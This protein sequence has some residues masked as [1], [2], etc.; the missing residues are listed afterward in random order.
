[1]DIPV[2]YK[3]VPTGICEQDPTVKSYTGNVD[4][5]KGQQTFFWFFEAI[6]MDPENAPLTVWINVQWKHYSKRM[7]LVG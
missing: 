3:E 7:D 1:V 2:R 6:S 5:S 4:V